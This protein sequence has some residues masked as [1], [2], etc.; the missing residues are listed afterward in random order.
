MSS[1]LIEVPVNQPAQQ[2][3][4]PTKTPCWMANEAVGTSKERVFS[5][6]NDVIYLIC[7]YVSSR[8]FDNVQYHQKDLLRRT[9]FFGQE[10]PK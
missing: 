1:Y 10:Q 6:L 5:F 3:T 7:I 4:L 8:I 9:A 2:S